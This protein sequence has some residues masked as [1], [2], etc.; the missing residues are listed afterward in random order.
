MIIA[1][2]IYHE[3]L[4]ENNMK[5]GRTGEGRCRKENDKAWKGTGGYSVITK[6]ENEYVTA[7][8]K[9]F[10]AELCSFKLKQDGT[11]YLWQA[12]STYWGRHAP[13]LFPIV[14]RLLDNE[15]NLGGKVYHLSQHGFARDMEFVLKE[16]D[17][18]HALYQLL[19]NE[20]TLEKYPIKFELL[21][22]YTLQG[23]ELLINYQVRNQDHKNMYFSIGAHPGFRCPLESG[24]CFEDYYLE[25][26]QKETANK[27]KLENGFISNQR[28]RVLADEHIIPLSYEL[29]KDDA[30]VFKNLQS[31]MITLK[32]RKSNKTVAMKFAGFPYYGIWSK[33]E[34]GAPFI[35]LE[36]W[37]GIADRFDGKK[38]FTE[39]EG[40]TILN[41]GEVF[42]CQHSIIIS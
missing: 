4:R 41:S 12:D 15:Y 13:V 24:E 42:S 22:E 17:A 6:L 21:I 25:F 39:K 38:E 11:E 35:C 16:S 31:E 28:E 8:I 1:L 26:S 34:G 32:S 9:S 7:S 36:P 18:Q 20:K 10:G 27:Y 30:L 14:G 33:P 23:H 29:F 19:A 3:N 37:Y 40:L 5:N 2:Y